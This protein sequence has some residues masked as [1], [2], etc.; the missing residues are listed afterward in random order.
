[1]PPKAPPVTGTWLNT[2]AV[3]WRSRRGAVG[4]VVFWSLGCEASL[5]MLHHLQ[6]LKDDRFGE[7]C[8]F[9]VHSARTPDEQDEDLVRQAIRRHR[10]TMP[11]VHDQRRDTWARYNPPG[12]PSAIVISRKQRASGLVAGDAD[13]RLLSDAIAV[14]V[15]RSLPRS[16]NGVTPVGPMTVMPTTAAVPIGWPAGLGTLTPNQIVVSDVAH[17]RLAFLEL[18]ADRTSAELTDAIRTTSAPGPL[19]VI[20][21]STVAVSLPDEG[22]VVAYVLPLLNGAPSATL[23]LASGLVRPQGITVDDDGSIVIADAGADRL[24]RVTLDGTHGTIAGG[25]ETG[26]T[27]GSAAEAQLGQPVGVARVAAGIAFLDTASSTLRLLTD[28][29]RVLTTTGA[30]KDEPG[31][32]D[33][34]LHRASLLHPR[35]ATA[36]DADRLLIADTGNSRLRIVADRAL[37]TVPLR[38]LSRPEATCR[39][40]DGTVLVADTGNNRL[41]VVDLQ[42]NTATPVEITGSLEMSEPVDFTA[43]A[44]ATLA[45]PFPS[46]TNGPWHV[47]VVSEPADLIGSPFT[48]VRREPGSVALTLSGTGEGTLMVQS[49]A[50][51]DS[52][53]VRRETHTV[54]VR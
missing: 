39:L 31:L 50:L 6:R 27:D 17:R 25:G 4:V 7:L 44:G 34:P 19:A 33:G 54:R 29:G 15:G 8:I 42:S 41:I 28:A 35:G 18:S 36:L 26:C 23:E 1:M 10:F 40:D 24:V 5:A 16:A 49:R 51:N 43:V 52:D 14:E 32:I 21:H 12:W 3:D 11:V 46:P 47:T 38:G 30:S 9:A 37:T 2:P 20:D 22:R 45:I 48:I 13:L 53:I